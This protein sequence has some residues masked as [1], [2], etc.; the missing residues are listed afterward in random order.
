MLR[1]SFTRVKHTPCDIVDASSRTR[2]TEGRVAFGNLQRL[3]RG[4]ISKRLCDAAGPA[5]HNLLHTGCGAQSD[6]FH[7][8]V[9]RTKARAA[10]NDAMTW[11]LLSGDKQT[12]PD[13]IRIAPG[14]D[15][16]DL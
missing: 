15:Q 13:G 6:Q 3:M 4:K 2:L 10:S 5:D 7:R 12:G 9:H 8:I 11:A 16:A 14:G 1:P